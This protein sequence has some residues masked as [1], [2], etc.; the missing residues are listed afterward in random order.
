MFILKLSMTYGSLPGTKTIPCPQFLVCRKIAS[1][2]QTFL[3]IKEQIQT[4]TRLLIREVRNPETK[5]EQSTKDT[6]LLK[7]DPGACS[8]V[9]HNKIFQF[10]CRNYVP[11]PPTSVEDGNFRLSIRFLEHCPA[12][13]PPTNQKRVTNIPNF[14]YKD[15]SQ[16][17]IREFRIFE[18]EP[19]VLS[20]PC[21]KH[22][23]APNST[24]QLIWA[25][26]VSSG[27]ERD[28]SLQ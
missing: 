27:R 3:N 5:E 13:S 24:F 16:K 1:A 11:P 10:F 8:G 12:T 17:S 28:L 18:H 15:F 23:F 9:I 6:A 19:P 20:S 2:S 7:Q 25:H 4:V 14:A 22:F 26:C 21:S